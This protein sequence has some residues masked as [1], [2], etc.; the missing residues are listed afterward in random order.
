MLV[1][2]DLLYPTDTTCEDCSSSSVA[3]E[4]GAVEKMAIDGSGIQFSG[5]FEIDRTRLQDR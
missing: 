5:G 2:S 1:A 4:A 3:R